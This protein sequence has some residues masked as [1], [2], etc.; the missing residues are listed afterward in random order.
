MKK[1]C[2]LLCLILIA[3]VLSSCSQNVNKAYPSQDL[4]VDQNRSWFDDFVISDGTVRIKC[5]VCILNQTSVTKNA[6]LTGD[7]SEDQK[8]GFIKE[9]K[10]IA[11]QEQ[12]P[13][14]IQFELIPGENEF[15]VLFV[16]TSADSDQ[17][18]NRLLPAIEIIPINHA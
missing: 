12:I 2:V 14:Q 15:D 7:F 8:N 3:V 4:V 9:N 1:R 13:G 6:C 11:Q 10:L 18:A 17:K 5:H 16:G